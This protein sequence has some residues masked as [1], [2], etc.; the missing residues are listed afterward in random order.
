MSKSI[1]IIYRTGHIELPPDIQLP[2]NTYVTVILP[3]D[4]PE[5]AAPDPAFSI[6]DLAQDIDPRISPATWNITFTA[7]Q[8]NKLIVHEP[9][10]C[11]CCW[12]DRVS[13]S[14]RRPTPKPCGFT[15]SGFKSSVN[16]LLHQSYFWR[17]ETGCLRLLC[18]G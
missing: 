9:R 3:D 17:L 4:L 13:Q 5:D 18:A 10:L 16:S 12:M 14:A 6:P 11:G 7:I 8:N 15:N 2:D 1:R